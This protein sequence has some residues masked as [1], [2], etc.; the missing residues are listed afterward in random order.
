MIGQYSWASA[1]IV[2]FKDLGSVGFEQAATVSVARASE[3]SM[4]GRRDIWNLLTGDCGLASKANVQWR[5]G[6]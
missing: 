3:S 4:S 1:L 5:T 6:V 2:G